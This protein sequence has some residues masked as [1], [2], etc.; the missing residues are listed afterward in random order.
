MKSH[1]QLG[2]VGIIP[3][4]NRRWAKINNQKL[5]EAYWIA[6]QK[7]Y[8]AIDVLVELGASS[9]T[10]YALSKENIKRGRDD[11][12]AVLE[13]EER[14]FKESIPLLKKKHDLK[15]FHA[16]YPPILPKR[17]LQSLQEICEVDDCS[18]STALPSLF[19]C[20]GYDPNDELLHSMSK[21]VSRAEEIVKTLWVPHYIDL[22][23]RTS[24]EKRMSGF[25]PLQCSYA[26]LFFE[27]Y[28][29]PDISRESIEAIVNKYFLR[30]RRFGK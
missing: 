7:L 23:I 9:V 29:F 6:T 2:N 28:F 18:R 24:G 4:G 8:L 1:Q 26:E 30:E 20:A 10:I 17:Y 21:T 13:A 27:P 19:I 15:V 5:D 11:L 3:D 22:V 25:L 14:F 12:E 16:G